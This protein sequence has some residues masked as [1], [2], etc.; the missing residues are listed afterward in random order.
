MKNRAAHHQG[1]SVWVI[2]LVLCAIVIGSWQ[3]SEHKAEKKRI[4]AEAIAKAEQQKRDAER[5]E[6]EKRLAQEKQQQDA[7]TASNKALDTLLSR[8]DDAIKVAGTTGRIALAGPVSTL[9]GIRREAEAMTVSPCMDPAKALMVASMQHS[10]DG[11]I[12]FMRNE[13][14]IGDTLAKIDFDEAAKKLAEF[15]VARGG[16]SK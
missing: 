13:M 12:T 2:L 3:Y 7:L 9:Q 6:L 1:G 11:F 14:K 16:C 4:A 15:K 8:W 10:I 5:A